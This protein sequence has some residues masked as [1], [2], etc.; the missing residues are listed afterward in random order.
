MGLELEYTA[1]YSSDFGVTDIATELKN[2]QAVLDMQ[3]TSKVKAEVA[4]QVL[5]AYVPELPSDRF[6]AIIEDIE[7][8]SSE[9]AY[10]EPPEPPEPP[11]PPKPDENEPQ[12]PQ[13]E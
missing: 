6:D 1:T 4:R 3:L 5:A 10:N 7:K 11:G 12:E 9:P 2:A 13:E 8:E